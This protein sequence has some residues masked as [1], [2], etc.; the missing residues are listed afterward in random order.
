VGVA[1]TQVWLCVAEES[2]LSVFAAAGFSPAT[3][4]GDDLDAAAPADPEADDGDDD[5]AADD[6]AA[7][8]DAADDDAADDDAADGRDEAAA[9]AATSETDDPDD[10]RFQNVAGEDEGNDGLDLPADGDDPGLS[11]PHGGD[12]EAGGEA[13]GEAGAE[14]RA[15]PA[16]VDVLA[17]EAALADALSEPPRRRTY[18]DI[19]RPDAAMADAASADGEADPG[20]GPGAAASDVGDGFSGGSPRSPR[21]LGWTLFDA[22]AGGGGADAET[23]AETDATTGEGAAEAATVD[24]A[25]SAAAPESGRPRGTSLDDVT[26]ADV[27]TGNSLTLRRVAS[28]H[29]PSPWAKS[30]RLASSP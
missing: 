2:A 20:S 15:P 16:S 5:D 28:G 24:E 9:T 4:Q 26:V 18:R 17:M 3:P 12:D 7:D 6:D 29:E 10:P 1:R 8:D 23:D 21:P 19:S 30:A 25:D 14:L 13:G 11:G 27:G 22:L